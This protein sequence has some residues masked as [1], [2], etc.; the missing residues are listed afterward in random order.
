MDSDNF[1]LFTLLLLP[2][3][4]PPS[5]DCI[6]IL[7]NKSVRFHEITEKPN[8]CAEKTYEKLTKEQ[9]VYCKNIFLKLVAM[10]ESNK[11]LRYRQTIERL[12]SLSQDKTEQKNIAATVNQLIEQGLL[13]TDYDDEGVEHIKIHISLREGWR[14]FI[15]WRQEYREC[16]D[17]YIQIKK[18]WQKWKTDRVDDNLIQGN[19]L[20][21]T[22][23]KWLIIS[24]ELSES[25]KKFCYESDRIA[26]E[27]YKYCNQTVIHNKYEFVD[28][29]NKSK[30]MMKVAQSIKAIHINLANGLYLYP[31]MEKYRKN[32]FS[33]TLV[34]VPKDKKIAILKVV[35]NITNLG[36][37]EAK[38]IVES[39]PQEIY[40]D[41]VSI[42]QAREIKLQLE[43]AG[44]TALIQSSLS[45]M[46]IEI[47]NLTKLK[48]LKEIDLLSNKPISS[49]IQSKNCFE[50]IYSLTLIDYPSDKVIEIVKVVHNITNLN[51]KEAIKLVESVPSI[52]SD[53]IT[54]NQ[55]IEYVKLFDELNADTEINFNLPFQNFLHTLAQITAKTPTID[56]NRY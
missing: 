43:E 11:D 19:L 16:R 18:A 26:L 24:D 29:N 25:I 42:K 46:G 13:I 30:S 55:S 2:T 21:N 52:I 40:Q 44:G 28:Y 37:K 6:I 39:V 27:K 34:E 33:V 50:R 41:I 54:L 49:F 12:L 47:E 32:L 53:R 36:L 3:S 14:R 7:Y 51:F 4:F 38:A 48:H 56:D 23:K 17:L 1:P 5:L 10:H 31:Y 8:Y 20:D 9:Q 45:D 35:R 15:L 22:R